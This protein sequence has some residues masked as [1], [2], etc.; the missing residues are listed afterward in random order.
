MT[1]GN[2][3]TA[4]GDV[5]D[6]EKNKLCRNMKVCKGNNSDFIYFYTQHGFH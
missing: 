4:H 6:V 3:K 5:Q 2:E 1:G